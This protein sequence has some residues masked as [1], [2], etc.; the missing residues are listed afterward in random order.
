MQKL[1]IFLSVLFLIGLVYSQECSDGICPANE[2]VSAP[3]NNSSLPDN[4]N[5]D[6]EINCSNFLWIQNYIME[7]VNNGTLNGNQVDL[8]SLVEQ[9]NFGL[10]D[11]L[12]RMEE[13]NK[14]YEKELVTK[15]IYSVIT[16]S[17]VGIMFLL[18]VWRTKERIELRKNA[19]KSS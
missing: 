11:E 3:V 14:K 15:N 13:L 7:Q 19:T 16:F 12:N 1:I 18:I 5:N 6:C 9:A 4:Y 17:S 8:M 2:T 10:Q